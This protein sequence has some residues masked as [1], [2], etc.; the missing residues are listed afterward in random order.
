MP[1]PRSHH[2]LHSPKPSPKALRTGSLRPFCRRPGL[3][4]ARSFRGLEGMPAVGPRGG[5]ATGV[6]GGEVYA[7]TDIIGTGPCLFHDGRHS[8]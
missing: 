5:A 7:V 4:L 2:P 1:L 3:S 8:P 6:W